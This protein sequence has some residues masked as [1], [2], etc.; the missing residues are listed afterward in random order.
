VADKLRFKQTSLPMIHQNHLSLW[1][2]ENR[3]IRTITHFYKQNQT[4]NRQWDIWT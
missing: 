4:I 2:W 1:K 3:C